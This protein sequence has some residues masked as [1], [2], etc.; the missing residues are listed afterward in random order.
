M[1]ASRSHLPRNLVSVFQNSNSNNPDFFSPL[2]G[3]ILAL[4]IKR[5]LLFEQ[6]SYLGIDNQ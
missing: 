4:Q 2:L 3:N 6:P 1:R 5:A